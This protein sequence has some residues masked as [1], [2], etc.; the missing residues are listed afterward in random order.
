MP[1]TNKDDNPISISAINTE[2]TSTTSN[3]LKTLSDTARTGTDPADLDGGPYGMGEFSEYSHPSPFT[4]QSTSGTM[5]Q[6]TQGKNSCL[7]RAMFSLTDDTLVLGGTGNTHIYT[8]RNIS[9][10]EGTAP[11][12]ADTDQR[13]GL[14]ISGYETGNIAAPTGWSTLTMTNSQ[15]NW[16]K[17]ASDFTITNNYNSSNNITYWT[18][19]IDD[20][21][22]YLSDS[23][24]PTGYSGTGTLTFS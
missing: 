8:I 23:G 24:D 11:S 20:E 1:I 3:S 9:S 6:F 21:T 4:S 15:I 10:K 12:S 18:F 2:N 17:S 19:R 7:R 16:S 22:L 14:V 13:Q 5:N